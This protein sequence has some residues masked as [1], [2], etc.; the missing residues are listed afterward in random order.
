[1]EVQTFAWCCYKIFPVLLNWIEL[2]GSTAS[3]VGSGALLSHIALEKSPKIDNPMT[4]SAS[5]R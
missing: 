1:M 5:K 2:P 3:F 4:Q